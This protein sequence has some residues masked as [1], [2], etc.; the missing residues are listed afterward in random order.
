MHKWKREK[1]ERDKENE[2]SRRQEVEA[3]KGDVYCTERFS[4]YVVGY[5]CDVV[6]GPG[7]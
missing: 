1:I 3:R 4:T 2:S 5:W 7:G 6:G